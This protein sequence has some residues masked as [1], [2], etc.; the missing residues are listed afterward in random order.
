MGFWQLVVLLIVWKCNILAVDDEGDKTTIGDDA[1]VCGR[2]LAI[3]GPVGS[4]VSS[5][6]F[7]LWFATGKYRCIADK[8]KD[9]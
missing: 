2:G 6:D 8:Q 4:C 9:R 3:G 7:G 1:E 5:H